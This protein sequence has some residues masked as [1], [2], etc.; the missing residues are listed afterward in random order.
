MTT[1]TA[2]AAQSFGTVVGTYHGSMERHH[3]NIVKV[4]PCNCSGCRFAYGEW[5]HSNTPTFTQRY[6]LLT[7]RMEVLRHVSESSFTRD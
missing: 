4:S 6:T 7:A 1:H 3:G 2:P 5:L